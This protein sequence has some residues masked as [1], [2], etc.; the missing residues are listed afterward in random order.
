MESQ[1]QT[2]AH[3]SRTKV[4]A[5]N[6]SQPTVGQEKPV[7]GGRLVVKS[8]SISSNPDAGPSKAVASGEPLIQASNIPHVVH[9]LRNV[10]PLC[11]DKT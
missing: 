1:P 3:A 10:S 9:A 7:W 6:F 5:S 4:V 2:P 8:V 11:I